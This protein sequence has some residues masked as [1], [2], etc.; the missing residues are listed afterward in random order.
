MLRFQTILLSLLGLVFLSLSA[1]AAD[2]ADSALNDTAPVDTELATQTNNNIMMRQ[3]Q[4]ID[5]FEPLTIAGQQINA[6]FL[7]ETL[8]EP[9][10]AIILFHDQGEALESWGVVTPLRHEMLQYGWSTLSLTLD[11]TF[12]PNI[13]LAIAPETDIGRAHV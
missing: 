3:I 9:H 6:A 5:G 7:E 1:I 11:Y 12:T 13:I 2:N 4:P 8:G 10:G